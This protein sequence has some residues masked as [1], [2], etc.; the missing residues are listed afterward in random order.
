VKG[1]T[2]DLPN[3]HESRRADHDAGYTQG[4]A[5]EYLGGRG[6]AT[7]VRARRG[8]PVTGGSAKPVEAPEVVLDGQDL[9]SLEPGIECVAAEDR[10]AHDGACAGGRWFG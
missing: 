9:D 4:R 1:R 6:D 10:G 3:E 8:H 5:H 2:H 7:F